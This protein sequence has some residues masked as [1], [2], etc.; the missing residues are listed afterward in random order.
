ML[1]PQIALISREVHPFG[2]GIGTYVGALAAFL[3][4]DADVTIF[5]STVHQDAME[6]P[7]ARRRR[8]FGDEVR[9]VYVEEPEPGAIG[10]YFGHVHCYGAR[11]LR[12]LRKEFGR[13][14]PDL[15]ECQDYLGE[16]A[17]TLQARITRE[18]FLAETPV[19]VRL[20]T[21]AEMCALLDGY[22]GDDTQAAFV[23]AL[24]RYCLR[25]ADR[26]LYGGGDIYRTYERYYGAG[27]LAPADRVRQPLSALG[28]I[29]GTDTVAVP[30][31]DGP[32]RLIYIGRLERRKGVANLVKAMSLVKGAEVR[33]TMVGADTDTAPLGTS[34][35]DHLEQMA[36]ARGLEEPGSNIDFI[37]N[38][39]REELSDLIDQHHAGIFPS[40]WECWPAVAL[41]TLARNRPIIATPVGGLCEMAQPGRSGWRTRGVSA[42]AL[43]E[44]I[45]H[46]ARERGALGA[47]VESARPRKVHDELCDGDSVRE[48]YTRCVR[49]RR[50]RPA[51]PRV[52]TEHRPLVSAIVPYFAMSRHIEE[53]IDSLLD[54]TYSPLEVILVNDGSFAIADRVIAKLSAR[55]P[56]R[57]ATQPNSGLG[58]AR[59]F[60]IRVSR[61]RFV[62]MLDADDILEPSFVE[63]ALTALESNPT[64]AYVSCWSRYVNERGIPNRGGGFQAISNFPPVVERGNVAGI[65][66]AVIRRSVFDRGYWYSEE[67]TSYEDWE[68]FRR[69]RRA[70]LY[71]HCVPE[72][73]LRYRVRDESMLREVGFPEAGRLDGELKAHL[74]G[75]EVE[76]TSPSD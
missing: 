18:A 50:A 74:R 69:M 22:F 57:V 36:N 62:T 7:E 54:Q 73:L 51:A 17:V 44:T 14:G 58:A 67:L 4:V 21:T 28:A 75:S 49:S 3:S 41:E 43:A 53:A 40:L 64:I 56:I 61:G 63:R 48:W 65:C 1:R 46:V 38:L 26:L 70:G 29:P 60:G 68:L 71:G 23:H 35:S 15:I 66:T 59:N 55:L 30:S 25:F 33:L 13:R 2:G 27:A 32:L 8:L 6:T 24:E 45:E 76:W 31:P 11:V 20:D 34:M 16:G 5:M 12:A 10:S 37:D 72:R 42:P 52:R 9:I 39:P 47:L 19:I